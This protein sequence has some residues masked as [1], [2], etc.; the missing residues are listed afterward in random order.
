M[1]L[2]AKLTSREVNIEEKTR[3][4]VNQD[5]SFTGRGEVISINNKGDREI[6][7]ISPHEIYIAKQEGHITKIET[8]SGGKPESKS[9]SKRFRDKLYL[10]WSDKGYKSKYPEFDTFYAKVMDRLD[11]LQTLILEDQFTLKGFL[12]Y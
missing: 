9:A 10:I 5:V 8:I 1:D 7:T 11:H 6:M 3:Q 2:Y 12:Q 4:D